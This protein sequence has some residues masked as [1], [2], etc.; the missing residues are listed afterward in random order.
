MEKPIDKA[1]DILAELSEKGS[2][3]NFLAGEAVKKLTLFPR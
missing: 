2:D 3:K 1:A